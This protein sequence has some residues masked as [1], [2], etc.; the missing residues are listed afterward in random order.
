M[1]N[2]DSALKVNGDRA[3]KVNDDGD[4]AWKVT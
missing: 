1:L 3:L 4:I 2:T